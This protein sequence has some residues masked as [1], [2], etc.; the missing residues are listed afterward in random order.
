[1]YKHDADVEEARIWMDDMDLDDDL[2]ND[3][4]D[5]MKTD[6]GPSSSV[7]TPVESK[8]EVVQSPGSPVKK[9]S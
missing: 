2:D 7:P 6:K 3:V 5:D 4:D 1:V 8:E 9:V